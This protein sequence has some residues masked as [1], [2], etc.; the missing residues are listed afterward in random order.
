MSYGISNRISN[1]THDSAS[2]MIKFDRLLLETDTMSTHNSSQ[3][4]ETS[5]DNSS[6]EDE[7]DDVGFVPIPGLDSKVQTN[8]C[9]DHVLQLIVKDGLKHAAQF[10]RVLSKT[11]KL[12]SH[13]RHS[14][15]A[16]ELLE[17]FRR[18]QQRNATRWHSALKMARSVLRIPAEKWE[19]LD[20]VRKLT[21]YEFSL[22]RDY[23]EIME[24]FEKATRETEGHKIVTS[25]L[26]MPVITE[27]ELKLNRLSIKFDSKFVKTLIT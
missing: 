14:T 10:D 16:S 20:Y 24:P 17:P 19:E 3:D 21:A 13:V 11:S 2:N 23:I 25:S 8:A 5:F 12:V 22:L 26:V 7:E 18:L 1:I 6:D 9:I 15:K 4:L 27:L